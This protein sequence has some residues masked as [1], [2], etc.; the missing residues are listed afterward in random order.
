MTLENWE[1]PG[2]A[3]WKQQLGFANQLRSGVNNARKTSGD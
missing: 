2:L 3:F 1:Q